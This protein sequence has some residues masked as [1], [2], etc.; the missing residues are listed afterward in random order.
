MAVNSRM[1]M[2]SMFTNVYWILVKKKKKSPKIP[3]FQIVFRFYFHIIL[4]DW[5][6]EIYKKKKHYRLWNGINGV[7]TDYR[8]FESYQYRR[9][10][11]VIARK[12]NISLIHRCWTLYTYGLIHTH[13]HTVYVRGLINRL[14][15]SNRGDNVYVHGN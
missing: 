15:N 9:M 7:R 5:R 1:R 14:K 6:S 4:Y 2:S 3:K 11:V 10:R 8:I 13:N 12:L